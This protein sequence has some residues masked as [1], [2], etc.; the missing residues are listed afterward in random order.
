M[1]DVILE[2]IVRDTVT[3][4]NFMPSAEVDQSSPRTIIDGE[5]LNYQRWCRFSA[6]QVGE[7][8]IPY[9]DRNSGARRELGY[10]LCH[11]G[12]NAVVRLLPTG[13]RT[14]VRSAHFTPLE[15]SPA[16]IKLIEDGI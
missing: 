12:D 1:D 13:R 5:R 6:G 2:G 3:L 9:P 11:Q 10:I 14:E 16:I 15:K 4:L 7:F 8:E